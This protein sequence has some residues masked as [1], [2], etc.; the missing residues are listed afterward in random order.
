MV[1]IHIGFLVC[2]FLLFL[3]IGI[4]ASVFLTKYI[5]TLSSK[6]DSKPLLPVILEIINKHYYSKSGEEIPG[7]EEVE[8]VNFNVPINLKDK[9]SHRISNI[10]KAPNCGKLKIP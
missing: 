1:E 5:E 6:N 8:V 3:L 9:K 7:S 10:V 4:V 2:L